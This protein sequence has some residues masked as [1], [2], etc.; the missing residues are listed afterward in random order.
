MV[1]NPTLT[2]PTGDSVVVES[3]Y[4][5]EAL[6]NASKAKTYGGNLL[7][8]SKLFILNLQLKSI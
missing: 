8:L 3:K 2:N 4:K 6:E 5:K 7:I 1:L